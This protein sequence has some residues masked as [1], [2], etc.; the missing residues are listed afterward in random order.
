MRHLHFWEKQPRIEYRSWSSDWQSKNI[1]KK[2]I[3]LLNCLHYF[4]STWCLQ[5][6]RKHYHDSS[7]NNFSCKYTFSLIVERCPHKWNKYRCKPFAA[8]NNVEPVGCNQTLPRGNWHH[9]LFSP[10]RNAILIKQYW[11]N[12]LCLKLFTCLY[13]LS[14]VATFIFYLF[15]DSNNDTP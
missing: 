13:S 1:V 7:C 6:I 2:D 12:L 4:F 14:A 3:Y 15:S 9:G 11:D 8:E 5:S 10:L